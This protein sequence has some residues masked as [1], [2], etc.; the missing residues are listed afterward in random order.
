MEAF[1]AVK[2]NAGAAGVDRQLI[3]DFEKDLKG[4]L[5]KVWYRI[6]SGSHVPPPIKAAQRRS[7]VDFSV[8]P[9]TPKVFAFQRGMWH[10]LWTEYGENLW[11]ENHV[12]LSGN[13][14]VWR[15]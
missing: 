4:N 11:T 9:K 8:A 3:A 10:N 2:A 13:L 1:K 14:K 6:S 7:P 15:R 5:Y 12:F